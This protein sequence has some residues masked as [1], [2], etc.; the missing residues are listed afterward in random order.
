MQ[1]AKVEKVDKGEKASKPVNFI[2][3]YFPQSEDLQKVF[4][5][6][7]KS[8]ISIAAQILRLVATDMLRRKICTK[9]QHTAVMEY[10]S[11]HTRRVA[12]KRQFRQF[13][14]YVPPSLSW[15]IDTMDKNMQSTAIPFE[16]RS[17]YI[18]HLFLTKA[19]KTSAKKAA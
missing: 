11:L 18:W 14:L 7:S 1:K 6:E 2:T 8:E 12:T 5:E 19:E 3:I 10:K 9:A 4:M 16:N 15:I 17:Q 13:S